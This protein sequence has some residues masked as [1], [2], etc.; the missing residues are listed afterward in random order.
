MVAV[1]DVVNALELVYGNRELYEKYSKLGYEKFNSEMYSWKY[2]TQQ[3][4]E[5]FKK[6]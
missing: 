3:W 4:V 2:I 6:L 5:L 1:Q